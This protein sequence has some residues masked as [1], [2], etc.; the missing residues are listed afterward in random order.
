MNYASDTTPRLQKMLRVLKAHPEGLTTFE[1]QAWT[2]SCAASTDISELRRS[3]HIIERKF[4]GV[5]NG[6][7]IHRYRWSGRPS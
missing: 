4:M 1:L 6:R 5:Q 2:N 3:G 7:K